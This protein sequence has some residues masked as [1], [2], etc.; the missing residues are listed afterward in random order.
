MLCTSPHRAWDPDPLSLPKEEEGMGNN[1]KKVRGA[2]LSKQK[3]KAFFTCSY[4][5]KKGRGKRRD[6]KL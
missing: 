1:R 4:P 5:K 2:F 6:P 3:P